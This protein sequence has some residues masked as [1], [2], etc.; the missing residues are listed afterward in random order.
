MRKESEGGDRRMHDRDELSLTLHS[1]IHLPDHG[2]KL[3]DDFLSIR[4]NWT[5]KFHT[6]VTGMRREG[7][8]DGGLVRKELGG[9]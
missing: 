5:H 1:V 6:M 3:T 9:R 7:G 4:L 8:R 2:N